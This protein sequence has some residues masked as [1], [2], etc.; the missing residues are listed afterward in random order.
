[1]VKSQA[2]RACDEENKS[3]YFGYEE[4]DQVGRILNLYQR[5]VQNFGLKRHK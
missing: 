1:M 2:A 3:L 4:L 5:L